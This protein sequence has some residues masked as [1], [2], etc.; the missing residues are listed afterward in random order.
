MNNSHREYLLGLYKSVFDDA[1]GTFPE[2]H[3]EL[4][5]DLS[6]LYSLVETRGL[7][8]ITLDLPAIGKEFDLSLSKGQLVLSPSYL[9]SRRTKDSPIPRLFGG[10][11][12][13]VFDECGMLQVNPGDKHVDAVRFLRQIYLLGKKWRV[14]CAESLTFK[15]V[16]EFFKV[17]EEVQRPTLCWDGPVLPDWRPSELSFDGSSPFREGL[18]QGYLPGFY[19]EKDKLMQD[20]GLDNPRRALLLRILQGVADR[21]SAALGYYEPSA[22]PMKHGPGVVADIKRGSKYEFPTW[23]Q[24]LEEIFPVARF[25]FANYGQWA[26]FV[27]HGESDPAYQQESAML[28]HLWERRKYEFDIAKNVGLLNPRFRPDEFASS[29][30]AVPKTQKGPRL[31]AA[32]PTAHQWCQQSIK[33]YL[34]GRVAKTWIG[35]AIAFDD[36]TKNQELALTASR[37]GEWSTIDLAAASDRMSCWVV[38]RMFRGNR[39]LLDALIATRTLFIWN[40]IDKKCATYTRLNKFSTMGS[41]VTFPVQSLVFFAV[42][43]AAAHFVSGS[44]VT[45]KSCER[46]ASQVRVFGDDIIVRTEN[47]GVTLYL[48][49]HLGFKVNTSKTHSE[50]SSRFRESCGV[51][52]YNGVDVTPAYALTVPRQSAPDSYV[53]NVACAHNFFRKRLICCAEFIRRTT[54]QAG[55]KDL[56]DVECGSGVF[57]WPSSMGFDTGMCQ[58]RYNQ[59]LQRFE[60]R[61]RSVVWRVTRMDDRGPSRLLQYFVEAP[62]PEFNWTSGVVAKGRVLTR[63]C[64]APIPA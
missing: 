1:R 29:L 10:L 48:L 51:D 38:E 35:Q 12:K 7:R 15:E 2:L 13:L 28:R 19:S 64:W 60:Y 14:P 21:M 18:Q 36:Q 61:A 57:G 56:P 45:E 59:D 50:A 41:A 8:V 4:E 3:K 17:D 32:E 30:I 47:T 43:L 37:T 23:N 62:L 58:I 9:S 20:Y 53:S 54:T 25:G 34:A 40:P 16:R 63:P 33:N 26:D 42:A 6:R 49:Q 55:L 52:A 31:I 22:W 27:S 39:T 11:M 24:R 46:L 5:R 44:R